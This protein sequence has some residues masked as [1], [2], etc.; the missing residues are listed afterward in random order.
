MQDLHSREDALTEKMKQQERKMQEKMATLEKIEEQLKKELEEVNKKKGK[1]K[2]GR[3]PRIKPFS[4]KKLV[5]FFSKPETK[6]KETATHSHSKGNT[7][8]TSLAKPR[9]QLSEGAAVDY[10]GMCVGR[11][12]D[13]A[14]V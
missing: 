14:C 11:W 8:M 3:P 7:K 2:E 4:L 5:R 10:A 9:K 13:G 6:K 12:M 1:E